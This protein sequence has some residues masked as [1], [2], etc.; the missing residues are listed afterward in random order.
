M[1]YIPPDYIFV[2]SFLFMNHTNPMDSGIKGPNIL[3]HPLDK[4]SR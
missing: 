3:R 4:I 1:R 2:S